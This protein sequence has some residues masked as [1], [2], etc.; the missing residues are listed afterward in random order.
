VTP[1]D[2]VVDAHES[3]PQSQASFG[4]LLWWLDGVTTSSQ[5]LNKALRA[6]CVVLLIHGRHGVAID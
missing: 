2:A 6:R 4:T 1:Q 3:L 5:V